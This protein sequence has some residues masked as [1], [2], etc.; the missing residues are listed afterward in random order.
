MCDARRLVSAR[1]GRFILQSA[2]WPVIVSHH[3][4]IKHPNVNYQSAAEAGCRE[5]R[6]DVELSPADVSSSM[7]SPEEVGNQQLW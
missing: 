4:P 5:R 1:S 7:T 3:E 2:A 6:S